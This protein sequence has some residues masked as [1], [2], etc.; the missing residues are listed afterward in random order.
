V[1]KKGLQNKITLILRVEGSIPELTSRVQ[2]LVKRKVQD[3]IGLD[4]PMDI[5][6]Y[7]GKIISDQRNEKP[8]PKKK[9]E[10]QKEL[11]HNVPFQGYR[12]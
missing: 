2:E 6:I 9:E 7:V 12:A 11:E 10:V 8:S 4:E 5:T 3:A 1:S